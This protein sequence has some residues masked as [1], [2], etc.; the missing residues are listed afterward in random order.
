MAFNVGTERRD[1]SP[2]RGGSG[3]ISTFEKNFA[4]PVRFPWMGLELEVR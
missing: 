1:K 4:R 2:V 3:K